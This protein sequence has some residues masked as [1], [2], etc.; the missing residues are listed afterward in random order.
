MGNTR[1]CCTIE[2]KEAVNK[3]NKCPN[4][5]MMYEVSEVLDEDSYRKFMTGFAVGMTRFFDCVCGVSLFV[6][7][8]RYYTEVWFEIDRVS[9]Y[10]SSVPGGIP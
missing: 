5:G 8:A 4:C 9:D 1:G 7:M 6:R 10:P 2:G 3:T